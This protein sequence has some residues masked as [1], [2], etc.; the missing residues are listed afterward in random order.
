MNTKQLSSQTLK[1][2]LALSEQ[3]ESYQA[4]IAEIDAQLEALFADEPTKPILKAKALKGSAGRK[5]ARATQQGHHKE[6]I[7]GL[8]KPAGRKGITLKEI[9]KQLR[10]SPNSLNSWMHSTGKKIKEIKKIG[11]G[12][13]AWVE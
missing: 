5:S 1:K 7:T 6:A 13:Y 9:R 12:Q 4:R 2:A 11:S 8:I 3:K 10:L